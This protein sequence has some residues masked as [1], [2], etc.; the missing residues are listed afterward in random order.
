MVLAHSQALLTSTPEGATAYMPAD[1]R[2]TEKVLADAAESLDF[3]EP[4][5]VMALMVLQYIPDADDP[6]GIVRRLL[7]PLPAGS[8]LTVSDTVRDID[9]DRVTEGAARLN[10]RMGP[11]RL[12]LRTRSGFE[13]FFDNLEMVERGIVPLPEWRA[14]GSEHPIRTFCA[15]CRVHPARVRA[16]PIRRSV[17]PSAFEPDDAE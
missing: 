4:V 3:G 13:R 12:T 16:A 11:T 6:L 17:C 10:E 1:I 8:Y 5:A 7:G 9:T 15:R 2:D 14:P